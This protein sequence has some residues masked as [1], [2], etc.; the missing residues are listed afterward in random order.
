MSTLVHVETADAVAHEATDA[1]LNEMVAKTAELI[2]AFKRSYDMTK[3]VLVSNI[4]VD[5]YDDG[6]MHQ[7][8]A[9]SITYPSSPSYVDAFESAQR[10]IGEMFIKSLI[11]KM[12]AANQG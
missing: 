6:A 9:I 11:E 7:K 1:I 3:P 2:P 5:V 10:I 8:N 12:G 4:T